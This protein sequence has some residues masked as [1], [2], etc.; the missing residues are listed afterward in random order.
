M[1]ERKPLGARWRYK[2]LACCI[3]TSCNNFVEMFSKM[4]KRK[5]YLL[6]WYVKDKL[7]GISKIGRIIHSNLS[8]FIGLSRQPLLYSVVLWFFLI[9]HLLDVFFKPTTIMMNF[10]L[11]KIVKL[12]VLIWKHLFCD[13]LQYSWVNIAITLNTESQL[14]NFKHIYLF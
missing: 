14:T 1:V 3:V 5:K 2:K 10:K 7:L 12:W 4:I 11:E 13:W 9:K 8:K 6:E